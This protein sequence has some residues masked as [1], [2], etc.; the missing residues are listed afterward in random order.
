M[1]MTVMHDTVTDAMGECGTSFGGF[2]DP[3]LNL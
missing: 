3:L 1:Q 2:G